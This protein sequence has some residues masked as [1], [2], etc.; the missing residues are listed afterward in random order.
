MPSHLL[1]TAECV[2]PNRHG[3][4]LPTAGNPKSQIL[5]RT[6]GGGGRSRCREPVAFRQGNLLSQTPAPFGNLLDQACLMLAQIY[7]AGEFRVIR[8]INNNF[9]MYLISRVVEELLGKKVYSCEEQELEVTRQSLASALKLAQGFG[10][11][12][13]QE[14]MAF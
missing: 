3:T 9:N 8:N 10:S 13:V 2:G 4:E 1:A 6:G 5:G 12:P 14:K 7:K 11:S